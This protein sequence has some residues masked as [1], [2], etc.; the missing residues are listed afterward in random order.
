[1]KI[2]GDRKAEGAAAIRIAGLLRS[3]EPSGPTEAR[4]FTPPVPVAARCHVLTLTGRLCCV[5]S[6]LVH[7]LRHEDQQQ[8]AREYQRERR[9]G[10]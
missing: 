3:I 4:W 7:A 5:I 2:S 6:R 8:R 9:H 10:K 1:M